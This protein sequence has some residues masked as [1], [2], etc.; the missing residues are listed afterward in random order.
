MEL[1]RIH[2]KMSYLMEI[3]PASWSISCSATENTIH[4]LSPY[5]GKLRSSIASVLIKNYSK[6]GD[7][8]VD[9]FAGSGTV[10]LESAILGRNVFGSDISIYAELLSKAK[11]SAPMSLSEALKRANYLLVLSEKLP[12]PNINLV[13]KWVRAFFHPKTLKEIL[14][15]AIVARRKGNEFYFAC[16]LG[17][18]HHQ[19][20]GFLSFPA[21]HLTPYLRDKK[22]PKSEYPQMYQYRDLKSRLIAKITRA[23]KRHSCHNIDWIF[24]RGS[25]ENISLP[26]SFDAVITS[27]PYMNALDYGRDN[28]LRLWFINPDL[29]KP[30]DSSATKSSIA[31]RKAMEIFAKKIEIGLKRNGYCV[32]IVGEGIRGRS[33]Q[34][35]VEIV[36]IFNR[37]APNLKLEKI[38]VDKIPDVRRSRRN[39]HGTKNEHI[40]I[41]KKH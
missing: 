23:Y 10:L 22:Y 28:R 36:D 21:S 16:F 2:E 12:D 7:L 41:L 19:R 6:E 1:T 25:I 14:K 38:I 39:H 13:P 8:I 32:L 37:Y 29:N 30:L 3:A 20:P 33:N 5:I 24:R 27:P 9:P 26:E 40:L 4:Q 17:I 11:L 35:S 18:L 31:F 15:F 34:L